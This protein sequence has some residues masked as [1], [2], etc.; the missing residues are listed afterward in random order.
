M[1]DRDNLAIDD[2]GGG[3]VDVV[4][5]AVSIFV[6]IDDADHGGDAGAPIDEIVQGSAI[7][8]YEVL[9][10]QQ[11][12]RRI[13]SDSKFRKRNDIGSD[14]SSFIDGIRDQ[15]A[16][17]GDIPD[18]GIDLGRGDSDRVHFRVVTS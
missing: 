6:K 10:K 17:S 4:D 15:T 1:V 7:S 9:R 14:A 12:F 3:V 2:D 13:A 16:V 5:V 11:V 18:G 8:A